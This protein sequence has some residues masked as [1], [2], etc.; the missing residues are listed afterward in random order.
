M[1]KN[2]LTDISSKESIR[3]GIN[4]YND[5]MKS[6]T[7]YKLAELIEF[8]EV[9]TNEFEYDEKAKTATYFGE[10]FAI[11]IDE[12]E[13]KSGFN[14]VIISATLKNRNGYTFNINYSRI[15]RM[16]SIVFAILN[17]LDVSDYIE[18]IKYKLECS[19][20]CNIKVTNKESEWWGLRYD[21]K[22]ILSWNRGPI[23]NIPVSIGFDMN[24]GNVIVS[25]YGEDQN[26]PIDNNVDNIVDHILRKLRT[27]EYDT[28]NE[29]KDYSTFSRYMH[30]ASKYV[31]Y[32]YN[33]IDD[34]I[35]EYKD[36]EGLHDKLTKCHS[37]LL[38][39]LKDFN[40]TIR[41]NKQ[42]CGYIG[43]SMR[44]N[45][46]IIL[47]NAV[48]KT[49]KPNAISET[50]EGLY[51]HMHVLTG[52][53]YKIDIKDT[54]KYNLFNG[55]IDDGWKYKLLTALRLADRY[56]SMS[57]EIPTKEYSYT[58]RVVTKKV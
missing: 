16:D 36:N 14:N 42:I 24:N 35:D 32:V 8:I 53:M 25:V 56:S 18:Y 19:L 57:K 31:D 50:T 41:Y 6:P 34:M 49:E 52:N 44:Y 17:F 46:F 26:I 11:C 15:M 21:W 39:F 9:N 33:S 47:S 1:K 43:Y 3:R 13:I 22:L 48:V 51:M 20:F 4:L 29:A 5:E 2:Y 30:E 10:E 7:S 12:L 55:D 38:R 37:E 58:E 45:C 27:L 40:F 54:N 28:L 23:K